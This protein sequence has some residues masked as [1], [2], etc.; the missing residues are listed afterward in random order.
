MAQKITVIILISLALLAAI[1]VSGCTSGT[2]VQSPTAVS[3]SDT[4][5]GLKAG[6]TDLPGYGIAITGG[7]T[8]PA[9]VSYADL[10]AMDFIELDDVTMLKSNNVSVTSDFVGVP[11]KAIL[12]K[13]GVPEGN[14]TYMLSASDGYEMEYTTGQLDKSVLALKKN[15]TALTDNI[16][17]NAIQLVVPGERGNTWMKVPVKI[18]IIKE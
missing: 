5:A 13:A 18:E 8:S 2:S 11:M 15:G 17:K 9:T 1:A 14:V 10:L 16:N 3:P 7:I 6:L 4:G 12:A